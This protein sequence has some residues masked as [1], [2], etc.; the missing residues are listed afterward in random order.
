MK[1]LFRLAASLRINDV[2]YAPTNDETIKI[3][4]SLADGSMI[5][6]SLIKWLKKV[7]ND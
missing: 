6:E 1:E 2:N 7:I 3:R 5:Y 4:L